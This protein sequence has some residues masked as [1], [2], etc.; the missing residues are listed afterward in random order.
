MAKY[1]MKRDG[2]KEVGPACCLRR[3]PQ[4]HVRAEGDR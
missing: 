1:S 2:K 4:R 3:T